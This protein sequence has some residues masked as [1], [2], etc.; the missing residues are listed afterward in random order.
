MIGIAN[1]TRRLLKNIVISLPSQTLLIPE[2][3][4]RK[5]NKLGGAGFRDLE[6]V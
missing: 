3:L 2:K 1:A 4:A 5:F 6:I